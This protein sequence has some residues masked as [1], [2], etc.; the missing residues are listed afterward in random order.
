MEKLDI[1]RLEV[2]RLAT[3]KILSVKIEGIKIVELGSA[4][5]EAGME[6]QQKTR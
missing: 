1:Q 6:Q 2:V 5:T 4:D 3:A